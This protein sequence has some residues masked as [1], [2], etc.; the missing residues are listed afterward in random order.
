LNGGPV[1]KVNTQQ[2]YAT[3]A[4]TGALFEELCRKVEVPV[5]HYVHRTDLPCGSTIGPITATLLGIRTVDVGNPMLSM[6]SAREM[7]GAD[8]PDRMTRALGA[9][10]ICEDPF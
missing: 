6:H 3:C 7:T 8:D 9:F 5:Q 4:R 2:R 10:L 1:I